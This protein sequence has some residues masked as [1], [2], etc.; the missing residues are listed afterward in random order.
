MHKQDKMTLG[1]RTTVF[2]LVVGGTLLA[3]R[4]FSNPDTN[5]VAGVIVWLPES[6]E[7]VEGKEQ[8]MGLQ[9]KRWLPKDTTF[10]KLSYPNKDYLL[11]AERLRKLGGDDQKRKAL[12]IE[13]WAY[14]YGVGASLIVAGADSRSLH[15]PQVCLVAQ[16]WQIDRRELV[17]VDTASGPLQVMDFHLSMLPKLET[18]K[19]MLDETGKPIKFRAHYFYWWV[20]PGA[21]TASDEQRVWLETWNS[22]LKG[23]RERWAYP[24]VMVWVNEAEGKNADVIAREKAIR[25]IKE[26][27]PSFQKSLGAEEKPG[28]RSLK[29][30]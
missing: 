22:I 10:Y 17:T 26:A 6:F 20:G 5:P 30:I 8:F 25:F 4:L 7:G 24:S 16:G 12:V 13:S 21:T 11:E 23:R 29:A 1:L 15:R 14:N 18:G 28:S 9:E 27:A 2:A 3:C 19:Q